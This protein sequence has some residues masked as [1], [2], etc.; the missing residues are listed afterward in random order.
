ML[1]PEPSASDVPGDGEL[2]ELIVAPRG[3]SDPADSAP[4]GL[5]TGPV[6][7]TGR[8]RP[9]GPPSL[10]LVALQRVIVDIT[11]MVGCAGQ[12]QITHS[13]LIWC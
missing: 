13:S 2:K 10:R 11:A 3:S 12:M 1:Y 5:L 7:S 6:G 4:P 8:A 9:P